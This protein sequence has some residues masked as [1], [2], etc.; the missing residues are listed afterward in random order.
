M[1]ALSILPT[2]KENTIC[3][4]YNFNHIHDYDDFLKNIINPISSTIDSS[5]DVKIKLLN[6]AHYMF[7]VVGYGVFVSIKDNKVSI[8]QPFANIY[9]TKP[10]S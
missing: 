5:D 4:E 10:G 3:I 2:S 8:F 7:N 1:Q 6:S 9:K